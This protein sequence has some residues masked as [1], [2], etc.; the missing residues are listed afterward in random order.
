MRLTAIRRGWKRDG[1]D[2][3]VIDREGLAR[4]P[5]GILF[6]RIRDRLQCAPNGVAVHVVAPRWIVGDVRASDDARR[7]PAAAG[8]DAAGLTR[9][10]VA[11]VRDDLVA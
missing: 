7:D 6:I 9:G 3:A 11:R 4:V 10:I 2:V 5:F 8:D 1:T